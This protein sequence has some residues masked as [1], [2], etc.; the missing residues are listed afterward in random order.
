MTRII[1]T[2]QCSLF[3]R[4]CCAK[5]LFYVCKVHASSL[6]VFVEY[7]ILF[8]ARVAVKYLFYF[9]IFGKISLNL[10]TY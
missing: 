10:P 1:I 6:L 7:S 9:I 8:M 4:L 2:W 3:T 5:V